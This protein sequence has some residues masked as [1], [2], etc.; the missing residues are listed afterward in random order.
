[1]T[2]SKVLNWDERYLKLAVSAEELYMRQQGICYPTPS[3]GPDGSVEILCTDGN[4]TAVTSGLLNPTFE[5]AQCLAR[6]AA[7]VVKDANDL[8]R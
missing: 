8:K 5:C 2:K 3:I 1:M 7:R 4:E 6:F